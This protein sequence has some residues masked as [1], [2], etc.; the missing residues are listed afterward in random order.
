MKPQGIVPIIQLTEL[1]AGDTRELLV[2]EGFSWTTVG[3]TETPYSW[4]GKESSLDPRGT[5]GSGAECC[6]EFG[7]FPLFYR[8]RIWSSDGLLQATGKLWA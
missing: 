7:Q 8:V 1:A 2:S 3:P 5:S 4:A 6:T